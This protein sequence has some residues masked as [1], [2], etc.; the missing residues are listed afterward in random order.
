MRTNLDKKGLKQPREALRARLVQDGIKIGPDLIDGNPINKMITDVVTEE[1]APGPGPGAFVPW[2]STNQ[3]AFA[4][5]FSRSRTASRAACRS[6]S[7]SCASNLSR[8]ARS[9]APGR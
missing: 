4:S 5:A 8:R 3:A 7:M 9:A 2:R 6:S 1:N